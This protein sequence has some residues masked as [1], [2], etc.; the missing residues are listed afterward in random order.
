MIVFIAAATPY[1]NMSEFNLNVDHIL[2]PSNASN[3]LAIFGEGIIYIGG[4]PHPRYAFKDIIKKV[5]VFVNFMEDDELEEKGNYLPLLPEGIPCLRFPI[6]DRTVPEK[7]YVDRIIEE[8]RPYLGKNIYFHC[9]G[10]TYAEEYCGR[11]ALVCCAFIGKVGS[12]DFDTLWSHLKSQHGRRSFRRYEP[13]SDPGQLDFLRNY[14]KK[15]SVLEVDPEL[16]CDK[17]NTCWLLTNYH[18][19]EKFYRCDECEKL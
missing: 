16:L 8:V 7:A 2:C 13:L 11:S 3:P 12:I 14:L 17:C 18:C 19:N 1:R 6:P 10:G 5:D 15:R 9:L 4:L